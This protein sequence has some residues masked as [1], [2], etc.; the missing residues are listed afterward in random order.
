MCQVVVDQNNNL[1]EKN[2]F[3]EILGDILHQEWHREHEEIISIFQY[4]SNSSAI[5]Y[6]D[7]LIENPYQIYD[8]LDVVLAFA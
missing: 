5:A 8:N 7:F 2:V 4:F 6:V 3:I 1:L